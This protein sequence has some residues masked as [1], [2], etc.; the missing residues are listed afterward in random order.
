MEQVRFFKTSV[1]QAP[2]D[3]T[4]ISGDDSAIHHQTH[5]LFT[6]SELE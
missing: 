5:R 3:L 6:K 1:Y 2:A 4:A